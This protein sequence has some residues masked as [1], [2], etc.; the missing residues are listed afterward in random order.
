MN[1]S[2]FSPSS[3][4]NDSPLKAERGRGAVGALGEF[5]VD[6]V[7]DAGA[8]ADAGEDDAGDDADAGGGHGQ[9]DGG[10]DVA[11][12]LELLV[13]V[14]FFEA[15]TEVEE[16]AADLNGSG[17]RTEDGA[18]RGRQ[19]GVGAQQGAQHCG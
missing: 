11:E 7:E 8:D 9:A 16:A 6:L 13:V 1:A 4:A 3:S 2:T 15:A 17:D 19:G 18:G 10:A 14:M 12:S 5:G